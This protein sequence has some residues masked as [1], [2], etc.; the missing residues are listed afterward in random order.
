MNENLQKVNEKD[1]SLFL[2]IKNIIDSA[3]KRPCCSSKQHDVCFVL[4]N[5]K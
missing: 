1:K 4:G 3:K 5:W 2:D